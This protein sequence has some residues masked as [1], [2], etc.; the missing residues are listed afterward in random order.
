MSSVSGFT[1]LGFVSVEEWVSL[2][3]EL[4]SENYIQFTGD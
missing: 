4:S 2:L 3:Y 1:A